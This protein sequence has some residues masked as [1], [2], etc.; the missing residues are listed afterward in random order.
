M[1]CWEFRRS[2][3]VS[4]GLIDCKEGWDYS[5]CIDKDVLDQSLLGASS[6]FASEHNIVSSNLPTLL[7]SSIASSPLSPEATCSCRRGPQSCRLSRKYSKTYSVPPHP[8]F[9]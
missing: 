5:D 3:R 7:F 4:Y 2:D 9:T 6:L 8:V 1:G